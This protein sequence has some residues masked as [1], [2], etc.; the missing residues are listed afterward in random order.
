MAEYIILKKSK[1]LEIF[2]RY[3]DDYEHPH[4]LFINRNEKRSEFRGT[5]REYLQ[6]RAWSDMQSL[7]RNLIKG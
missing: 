3:E 4:P 1:F 6:N 5:K 7:K 2:K